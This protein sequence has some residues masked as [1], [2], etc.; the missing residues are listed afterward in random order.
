M[1]IEL[2]HGVEVELRALAER[3]GRDVGALVAEAVQTYLDAMAITD[4][5]PSEAAE[6]QSALLLEL[7]RVPSWTTDDA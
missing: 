5:G 1:N 3:E 7:P 6:A 4:V 2:P